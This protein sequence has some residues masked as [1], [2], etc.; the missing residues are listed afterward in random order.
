MDL[1]LPG[2]KSFRNRTWH[3][4]KHQPVERPHRGYSFRSLSSLESQTWHA[5]TLQT[6]ECSPADTTLLK[7]DLFSSVFYYFLGWLGTDRRNEEGKVR[8]RKGTR[9]NERK[10]RKERQLERKTEAET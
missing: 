4:F 5:F 7:E 2:A 9:K 1:R 8:R 6:R 10:E 3:P